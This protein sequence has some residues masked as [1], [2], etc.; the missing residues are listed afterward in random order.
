VHVVV[1]RMRSS[2]GWREREISTLLAGFGAAPVHY[3]PDDQ[4]ALDRALAAGRSP[5]EAGE[6][7]LTRAHTALLAAVLPAPAA[8]VVSR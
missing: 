3:L 7:A 8:P 6:S 5:A 2:L 1:N 4:A